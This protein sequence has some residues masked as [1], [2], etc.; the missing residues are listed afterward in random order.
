M[1]P[2]GKRSKPGQASSRKCRT[3]SRKRS[4]AKRR[5][6]SVRETPSI[7]DAMSTYYP[8]D[9]DERE[10]FLERL[11]K[12]GGRIRVLSNPYTTSDPVQLDCIQIEY[13]V[14]LDK[15]KIR[16]TQKFSD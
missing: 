5:Y 3:S 1:P 8:I 9:E 12:N 2:R 14:A 13:P 4:Q 16:Y 15:S 6:G 10:A 7:F 11:K